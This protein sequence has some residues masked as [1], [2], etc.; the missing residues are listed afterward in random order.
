MDTHPS[1]RLPRIFLVWM[2]YGALAVL[3]GPVSLG[4]TNP[5][6]EKLTGEDVRNDLERD[7]NDGS[8]DMVARQRA[9]PPKHQRAAWWPFDQGPRYV[10]AGPEGD[11]RA[12]IHT[13]AGDFRLDARVSRQLP[14]ELHAAPGPV[15][16]AGGGGED[17]EPH[18]YL[19][20]LPSEATYRA[21]NIRV[22]VEA[23]GVELVDFLP[24]EAVIL[25]ARPQRIPD[26]RSS[27][28]FDH[29]E[30]F[31]PAFKIEPALGR[32][33]FWNRERAE[34]ATF[35]LRLIGHRGEDPDRLSRL[36][37]RAGGSVQH[38]V[39]IG[40]RTY[41]EVD[42][43]RTRVF[44]LARIGAVA[45]LEE[46]REYRTL[47]TSGPATLQTG[48]YNHGRVPFFDV[49]VDGGGDTRCV[50]P[51][52]NGL[53]DTVAAGGDR[54]S[55]NGRWILGGGDNDCDTIS[56]GATD[57]VLFPVG[58]DLVPPQLVCVAD[59]G[60]SLDAAGLSH[61]LT[62]PCLGGNCPDNPATSMGA[63]VGPEHRKVQAYFTGNAGGDLTSSGDL[64]NCDSPASGGGSHGNHYYARC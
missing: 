49:G 18:A 45:S 40:A 50:G 33:P 17:G 28:L 48:R 4:G 54:V 31:H 61:S 63:G 47:N 35:H 24:R 64:T 9:L 29:V 55:G 15:V 62:D 32:V 14:Q 37:E 16:E 60:A 10:V 38:A 58:T 51:G 41:L 8:L 36:V 43:H 30:A 27:P 20:A 25:R 44:D 34:S 23:L 53:L 13:R 22:Q 3:G 26:V 7:R 39:S 46:V 6:A 5:L 59:N 11:D 21:G 12:L 57:D 42:V 52:A 56:I 1:R 19:I 2:V